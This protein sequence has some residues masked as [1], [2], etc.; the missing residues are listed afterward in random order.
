MTTDFTPH[1]LVY[2]SGHGYGH[3]AQIAP[4]LNRLREQ[5]PGLRLTVISSVPRTHL[6]SRIHGDFDHIAE[7][8]D[9]GMK[10]ASALD[11][12]PQESLNTYREFHRDW[13]GNITE[14]AERIAMLQPDSVLSN[15]AY[16]PLAAARMAGVPC[17]AMC[18][19]NWMDIFDHYCGGMP[20]AEQILIQMRDAYT[21]A[22]KF[23]RITP[24]ME[25]SGIDNRFSIGPIARLGNNRRGQINQRLGLNKED[26]LVLVSMGGIET[27]SPLAS[28]PMLEG[29]RWLVSAD[30]AVP[31]ADISMLETLGMDFTDVLHSCDAL[32]CKPG[33]GSF[34]EAACN[35]VP[36][37]Y[38]SRHDWPEESCLVEW[39]VQHGRCKEIARQAFE[40]GSLGVALTELLSEPKPTTV[41]PSGIQQAV[42]YLLRSISIASP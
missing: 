36:V 14:E 19:L 40:A 28:W 23:L 11:V 37:L 22:D 30:W 39:L 7:A 20:G 4:V 18:S 26:K 35:G 42:D 38:V 16:L 12:L 8:T 33:Y 10:M 27:R 6:Q 21:A 3:V 15:I 2:V 5:L 41:A 34:T 25:M 17:V 32:V 9:F 1:F 31:R 29:V 24:G 13:A